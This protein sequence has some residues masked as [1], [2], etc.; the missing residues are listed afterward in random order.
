MTA[1]IET[2]LSLDAVRVCEVMTRDFVRLT[3]DVSLLEAFG[4]M[5]RSGVHHMPV[6]RADGRCLVLLDMTTVLRRLPEDLVAQGTA[7]LC[8]PGS[9]GPLSVLADAPLT[10]AAAVMD[11]A[12][13]DACCAVDAQG[14]MVGLLTA[15][16]VLR[17][18]RA[19][20]VAL[21]TCSSG[22]SGKGYKG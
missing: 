8:P 2:R 4:A 7:P 20:Q 21:R 14:R 18:V 1:L 11:D 12:G 13:A 19:P 6:V 15:R 10:F 16:D 9:A 3:P 5:V 17:V 22:E